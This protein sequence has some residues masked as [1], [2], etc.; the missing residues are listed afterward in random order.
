MAAYAEGLNV[1]HGAGIGRHAQEVDAETTPLRDPEHYQYDFDLADVAEVW[2]RGQRH[3]LVAARPHR[4]SAGE[5]PGA[6]RIRRQ[7]L[8]LGRGALDD[9]GRHRRGG[10]RAGAHRRALRALLLARQRRLRRQG[11]LGHAPRVRRARGEEGVNAPKA[12]ALVFYGATGDL[13]FKKIFPALQAMVRRGVLDVPVIGVARQG[14]SLADLQG[15]GAGQRDGPRRRG[16]RGGLPEAALAAPLR[17]RGLRRPRHL[18]G[19]EAGARERATPGPL[20]GHPAGALR[21]GGQPAGP[22]G[23]SQGARLVVEKPFGS[24]LASAR[25]LNATL[26]EHFPESHVFR[27]DHYLGKGTVQNLSLLPLRQH[28]PRAHLEPELRRR[29][30][31]SPWPRTSA[32]RG[33]AP[34]TTRPGPSATWSRTTSSRSSPTSPWSRR[35]A[36]TTPRRCAPRR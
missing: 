26:H 28:L 29:T 21:A 27:I 9:P 8:R 13:A 14:W 12:D 17:G 5:G 18:R 2:R 23:L 36:A 6:G 30:C 7:G 19:A 1:L 24:D 20:H 11:P 16:G 15:A 33:A 25:K 32:S 10:A 22:G 3:R 4:R 31:R 34:S 35:P